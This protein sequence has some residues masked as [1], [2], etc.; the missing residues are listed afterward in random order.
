MPIYEELEYKPDWP[1]AQKRLE[2]FWAGEIVDRAVI[3]IVAPRERLA[4]AQQ[5]R[6]RGPRPTPE[7]P[8]EGMFYIGDHQAEVGAPVLVPAPPSWEAL[9]CDPEYIINATRAVCAATFYG[10]EAPPTPLKLN[11]GLLTYGQVRKF[12]PQTAWVKT[13]LENRELTDYRFDPENR[14]WRRVVELTQ[15]LVEDGRESYVVPL[16]DILPAAE[17]LSNLRGA[18]KLCLDL[19]DRQAE[20]QCLLD[21]LMDVYEWK[22]RILYD[23]IDVERYGSMSA[24]K[25]WAPG[26][27]ALLSCDFSALIGPEHF[28]EFVIPQIEQIL[29]MVDHSIYHLDGPDAVRHLPRLLEIEG[30]DGIQWSPGAAQ[31]MAMEGLAWLD[32]FETIQ[33][34]GKL[35]QIIVDYQDVEAALEHL[36][37]RGLFL[38]CKGVPSVEAAEALLKNVEKW[39]CRHAWDGRAAR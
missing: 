4:R 8:P 28:E 31:P 18:G 10:G 26:R 24:L 6:Y 11:I 27:T 34:A 22:Y 39:S 35:L 15:A 37:P 17:T 7:S 36:D 30:L 29:R 21:H 33:G 2:A 32:M 5:A 25:I 23:I 16:A 1:Q 13:E 14:W 3:S 20:V 19:V 9:W 38:W 12:T